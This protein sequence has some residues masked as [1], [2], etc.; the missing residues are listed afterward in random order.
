[1]GSRTPRRRPGRPPGDDGREV[2]NLLLAAAR[3]IC[4][5]TGLDAASTKLIAARAG[6]NP[7]MIHYY[8]GGKEALGEAMMRSAMAPLLER[9][10]ALANGPPVFSLK[11]VLAT[12]VHTLAANPW[13]PRLVVREV[14]PSNGRFRAIFLS[15]VAGRAERLLPAIAEKAQASG[16]ADRDLDPRLIILSLVSLAVF[17]FVAA[18]V[19]EAAL[20]L[21]LSESA[22]IDTLI[23]HSARV[24]S[25]GLSPGE[26]K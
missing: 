2:K 12:Y 22:S 10:D 11:D 26:S 24:L 20:K 23:E 14:L 16:A 1:M 5:E 4:I 7:A 18:P 9:L 17:P 3:D 8:F 13:L 15:E 25:H 19:V 21:D 6:V